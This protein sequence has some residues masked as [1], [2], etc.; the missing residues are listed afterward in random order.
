[1]LVIKRRLEDCSE[2][3]DF[4]ITLIF[5]WFQAMTVATLC[6][7]VLKVNQ[8]SCSCYNDFR[9]LLF[10]ILMS[11]DNAKYSIFARLK[12][13]FSSYISTRFSVRQEML[14]NDIIAI[15]ISKKSGKT[16]SYLMIVTEISRPLFFLRFQRQNTSNENTFF[17]NWPSIS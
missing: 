7:L 14:P 15:S 1:M 9:T 10:N 6:I 11:I 17:C 12:C 13:I 2:F 3:G 16:M 8:R 4:F 5:S